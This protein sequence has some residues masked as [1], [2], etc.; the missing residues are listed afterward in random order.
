M[1][2]R[3]QGPAALAQSLDRPDLPERLAAVEVLGEDA[4]GRAAE[5]VAAAR[6]GKGGVAEVVGEVEVGIIHPHR[7]AQ[8]ERYEANLLAIARDEAQ[9][10]RDHL[11]EPLERPPPP[12]EDAHAA[13]VH[14]VVRTLDLQ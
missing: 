12:L 11:L 9:L 4:G 7:A 2:L 5:L 10:A 14:R 8:A 1:N 3:E 6:R 13:D